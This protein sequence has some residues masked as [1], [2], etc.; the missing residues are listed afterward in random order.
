MPR[1]VSRRFSTGTAEVDLADAVAAS[2]SGG[3]LPHRIGERLFIDGGYRT[4][5]ENADLASGYSRVLV[6]SPFGGRTRLPLEW[7]ADLATQVARL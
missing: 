4:N 1:P 7:G 6:L 2:T 3:A 5:A